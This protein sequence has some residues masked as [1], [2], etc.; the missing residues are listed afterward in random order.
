MEKNENWNINMLK[1]ISRSENLGC[2]ET[3]PTDMFIGGNFKVKTVI[4]C[5]HEI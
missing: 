4:I 5:L 1:Q 2:L 3:H